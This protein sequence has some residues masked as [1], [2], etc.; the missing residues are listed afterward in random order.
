MPR[1]TAGRAW[2]SSR[3]DRYPVP[4]RARSWSRSTTAASADRTSICCSTVGPVPPVWSPATSSRVPSPP[5]AR[6]STGGRSESRSSGGPSPRCGRCRR[7]L[8][9]KPSQCE[10]AGLHRR[11]RRR[12]LRPVRA[13]RRRRADPDA[14]G[15]VSRTAALAEPLAVALHGITRSGVVPGDSDHGH[16]RRAHRRAVDRR[17]GRPGIGPV[18]A[19]EPG[20]RRAQLA[21]DLGAVEVLDPS[22]LETFPMWEPE[23]MADRR[24]PRGAGVLGPEGGHG[25]GIPPAPPGR[26]PSHWSGRVSS[27]RAFDPNRLLL[28]E[29]H[30]VGSFVYDHGGF[31]RAL[32]LLAGRRVPGRPADRGRRRPARRISEALVGLAQGRYAGKVMVDPRR[33]G[34]GRPAPGADVGRS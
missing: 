1:S 13:G 20:A 6:G 10:A 23:R 11:R 31:D 26:A 18:V 8:E 22:D 29:L 32:D 9:G 4:V 21:R 2:W 19:V 30:V 3:S 7:C 25:G 27:R 15:A 34:G 14:R 33:N 28:N 5:W 17:P 24:R 16:R 12:R